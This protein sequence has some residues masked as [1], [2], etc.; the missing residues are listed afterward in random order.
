MVDISIKVEY[1]LDSSAFVIFL[2]W[3]TLFLLVL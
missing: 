2:N 3:N 1:A